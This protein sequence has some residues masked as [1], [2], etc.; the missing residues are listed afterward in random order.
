MCQ[1][2]RVP[3]QNSETVGLSQRLVVGQMHSVTSN[4]AATPPKKHKRALSPIN[5][6]EFELSNRISA[7]DNRVVSIYPGTPGIFLSEGARDEWQPPIGRGS[8]GQRRSPIKNCKKYAFRL[9]ETPFFNTS[10]VS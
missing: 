9:Q 5:D 1:Y 6:T 10:Y 7:A 8:G 4:G 3:R 2:Q